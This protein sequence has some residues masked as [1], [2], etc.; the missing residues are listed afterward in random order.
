[1]AIK[2]TNKDGRIVGE[3]P[4]TGETIPIEFGDIHCDQSVV[5]TQLNAES[6]PH[7]IYV[8]EHGS[9]SNDGLSKETAVASIEEALARLINIPLKA[10]NGDLPTH[11]VDLEAGK[12]FSKNKPVP[13]T[14]PWV[15]HLRIRSSSSQTNATVEVKSKNGFRFNSTPR[16]SFKDVTV[17][18][19]DDSNRPEQIIQAHE[20]T[21]LYLRGST[22][23]T[24][25]TLRQI[26][27]DYCST[28]FFMDSSI[29]SGLGKHDGGGAVR[30]HGCSFVVV[31][32]TIQNSERGIFA[33]RQ[34]T[35]AV[36]GGS[37]EN[38]A[39][40]MQAG[41]FAVGKVA[42]DGK[43][44]NCDVV[45]DVR[46]NG[47]IKIAPDVDVV[48]N[49]ELVNFS[50]GMGTFHDTRKGTIDIGAVNDIRFRDSNNNIVFE[51]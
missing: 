9:D 34:G 21:A 23:I 35:W 17:K 11:I 7:I 19:A 2:I 32:G 47:H 40:A 1:M 51:I 15:G 14:A 20:C 16:V 30:T 4:N 6:V 28:G 22:K 46:G 8:R 5:S 12:T 43:V 24:G 31:T 10:E 18:A 3:D 49:S 50:E 36:E 26:D 39:K 45:A 42:G 37:I 13:F 27:V 44:K 25:A 38:C 41:D 29:V 33:T 48:N